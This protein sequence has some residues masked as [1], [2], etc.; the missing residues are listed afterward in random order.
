MFHPP[1][2]IISV[3][4]KRMSPTGSSSISAKFRQDRGPSTATTTLSSSISGK[5]KNSSPR[6][7]RA[8]RRL[9]F[10]RFYGW[11]CS[12]SAITTIRG[13]KESIPNWPTKCSCPMCSFRH[14]PRRSTFASTAAASSQLNIAAISLPPVQGSWNRER[15]TGYKIARV[16]FDHSTGKTLGDYEDFVTGFVTPQGNVW[17]RPVGLTVCKDGSLLFSEDGNDTIWRV[18]YGK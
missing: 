9:W 10:S 13:T 17:G 2:A 7:K 12:I 5:P 18:S 3:C 14:T 11:P 6:R 4:R 1:C 8:G 16:P 15:H